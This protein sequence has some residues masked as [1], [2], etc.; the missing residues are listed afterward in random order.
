M[1]SGTARR[2]LLLGT[3]WLDGLHG[4]VVFLEGFIKKPAKLARTAV[5]LDM[6]MVIGKVMM[7]RSKAISILQN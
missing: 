3:A 1:C 2:N 7:M 4:N 5:N 6:R